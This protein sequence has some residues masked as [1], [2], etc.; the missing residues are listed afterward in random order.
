MAI[1]ILLISSQNVAS[2]QV[3]PCIGIEM[4]DQLWM[5]RYILVRLAEMYNIDVTFDPK[6]IPGDWNGAGGHTNFSSKA[7]RTKGAPVVHSLQGLGF[8][9]CD[10]I[11]WAII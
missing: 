9:M 11:L 7:T 6:P 3:G 10:L 1:Y 8:M 4:G 5:S 2:L